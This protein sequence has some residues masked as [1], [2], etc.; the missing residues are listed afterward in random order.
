MIVL[1][2]G[3]LALV[4]AACVVLTNI[5]ICLGFWSLVVLLLLFW[6]CRCFP[7][8]FAFL[9]ALILIVSDL[10]VSGC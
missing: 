1:V 2:L 7:G 4:C 6:G 10:C 9:W 5:V 3:G 8:F